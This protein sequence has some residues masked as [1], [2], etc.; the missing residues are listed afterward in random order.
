[1]V[2]DPHTHPHLHTHT[3]THAAAGSTAL[4]Q[5]LLRAHADPN[6]PDSQGRSP[7]HLAVANSQNQ[8]DAAEVVQLLLQHGADPLSR[9]AKGHTPQSLSKVGV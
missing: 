5:L 8:N 6:T 4:T 1:M 9:D 7:L 2:I 3:C